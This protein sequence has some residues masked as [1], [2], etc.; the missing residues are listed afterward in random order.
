MY[1]DTCKYSRRL[2]LG[3]YRTF[4]AF[5]MDANARKCWGNKGVMNSQPIVASK[6][7]E[8]EKRIRYR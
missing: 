3:Q 8:V 1:K 7:T 2:E 4:P 5:A 6:I